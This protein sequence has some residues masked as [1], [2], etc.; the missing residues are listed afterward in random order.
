MIR[1]TDLLLSYTPSGRVGPTQ[2]IGHS[3]LDAIVV[4]RSHQFVQ[5]AV[6]L[7]V[8]CWA[9]R[10]ISAVVVGHGQVMKAKSAGPDGEHEVEAEWSSIVEVEWPRTGSVEA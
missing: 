1:K 9:L 3:T 6:N 10:F 5:S 7:R 2:P 4:T 8:G